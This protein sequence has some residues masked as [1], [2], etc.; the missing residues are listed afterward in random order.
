[1]VKLVC[2]AITLYQRYIS[3]C[4]PRTCR[5]APSCSQYALEAF[6][7]HGLL[8]GLYLSLGRLIRCHP[9]HSGGYEPVP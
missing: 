6:L 4:L 3:P 5:F 2:V 8:K 1:V 7:K 9:F